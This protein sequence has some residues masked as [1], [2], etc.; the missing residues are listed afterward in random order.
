MEF[1]NI[2][3]YG[4]LSNLFWGFFFFVKYFCDD[5]GMFVLCMCLLEIN[6]IGNE[7]GFNYYMDDCKIYYCK[8]MWVICLSLVR[9]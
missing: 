2:M 9:S 1:I 8:D 4:V 7:N 3:I 6:E 5:V